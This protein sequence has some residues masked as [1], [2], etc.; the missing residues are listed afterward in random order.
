MAQQTEKD[1]NT[2]KNPRYV[3]RESLAAAFFSA[4]GHRFVDRAPLHHYIE[5]SLAMSMSFIFLFGP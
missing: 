4:R 5:N 1:A 3:A 2:N